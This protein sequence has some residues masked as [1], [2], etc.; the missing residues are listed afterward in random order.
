MKKRLKK[1]INKYH[2]NGELKKSEECREE[3][4]FILGLKR[5]L[6]EESN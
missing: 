3:F 2:L 4:R 6:N 1:R 5:V